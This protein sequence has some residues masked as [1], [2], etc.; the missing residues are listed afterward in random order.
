ML[1]VFYTSGM[2]IYQNAGRTVRNIFGW[3]KILA[4]SPQM[5]F[6]SDASLEFLLVPYDTCQDN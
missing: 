2:K 4:S 6:T 3:M 1:H 5:E